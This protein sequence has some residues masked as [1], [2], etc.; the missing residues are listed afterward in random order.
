MRSVP[1]ITRGIRLL[2]IS[3]L[4]L[5]GARAGTRVS[6]VPCRERGTGLLGSRF[7]PGIIC[8]SDAREFTARVPDA[9]ACL[10]WLRGPWNAGHVISTFAAFFSRGF[11]HEFM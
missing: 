1:G 9:I 6:G 10:V 5:H 3:P 2:P 11:N 8:P 4:A 7:T